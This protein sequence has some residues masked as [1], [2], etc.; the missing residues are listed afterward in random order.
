MA[1][2]R[3]TQEELRAIPQ[4]YGSV[5]GRRGD[6]SV[7]QSFQPVSHLGVHPGVDARQ[8]RA[9]EGGLRQ[10][11]RERAR[12]R[13]HH[14]VELRHRRDMDPARAQHQGRRVSSAVDE[15]D[16]YGEGR[17]AVHADIPAARAVLGRAAGHERTSV[18]GCFRA[19]ALHSGTLHSEGWHQV[20]VACG[21]GSV[22]TAVVGTQFHV[23]HRPVPRLCADVLQVQDGGFHTRHS[24][25]HHPAACHAGT[26]EDCGRA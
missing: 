10:P 14:A 18:C 16:G 3:H 22:N 8:E 21:D 20:G 12:P 2:R 11:D 1:C 15:P 5:S 4:G 19:D 9:C 13:L 26:Q 25:V 24:R 17:P 23:V 6:R 7:R